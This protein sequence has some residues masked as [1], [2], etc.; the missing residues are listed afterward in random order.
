MTPDRWLKVQEAY[1]HVTVLEPSARPRFIEAT[2]RR[3]LEM[4]RELESLL[5]CENK[6]GK[7]LE[8]TAIEAL[9]AE[10]GGDVP[11]E[12][13]NERDLVGVLI[14]DRYIVRKHIGSGGGGDVYQAVHR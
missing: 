9:V 4:R 1:F 2:C 14:D 10:Y 6:I 12:P 8:Q 5:A 11:D 3:D 7:F 13:A